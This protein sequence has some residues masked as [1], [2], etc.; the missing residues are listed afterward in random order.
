[1]KHLLKIVARNACTFGAGYEMAGL[2]LRNTAT[3][4]LVDQVPGI[5][6]RCATC[7]KTFVYFG[8]V[9]A[10]LCQKDDGDGFGREE[11]IHATW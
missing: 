3:Q 7:L 2:F 4:T 9:E 6:H 8:R 1:M 5:Y 10:S 11:P